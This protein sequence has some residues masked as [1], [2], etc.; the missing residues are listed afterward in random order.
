MKRKARA[1]REHQ[2]QKGQKGEQRRSPARS[3]T[4]EEQE[5]EQ[6]KG[7]SVVEALQKST[8]AAQKT[9]EAAMAQNQGLLSTLVE[10]GK[11]KPVSFPKHDF[12]F[13]EGDSV[14]A[15]ELFFTSAVNELKNGQ[16]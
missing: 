5:E 1:Q 10:Q 15:L 8:A 13:R 2:G 3:D 7:D 11:T 6:G 16:R 9:A 12:P 4:T 14:A